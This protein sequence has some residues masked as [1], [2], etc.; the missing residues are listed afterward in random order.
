MVNSRGEKKKKKKWGN[1]ATE[2]TAKSFPIRCRKQWWYEGMVG[3]LVECG[4]QFVGRES[5][6][7]S[8][9]SG[10]SFRREEHYCPHT[11]VLSK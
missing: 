9:L 7:K 10:E 5:F 2:L 11:V 6:V 1:V 3:C 4:K 8:L